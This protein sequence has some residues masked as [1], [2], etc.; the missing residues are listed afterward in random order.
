MTLPITS[1]L[2]AALAILLVTLG[3]RTARQRRRSRVAIGHGEDGPLERHARAHANLA[4]YGPIFL[5]LLGLAE[6]QGVPPVWLSVLALAFFVGRLMHAYSL[7][8]AEPAMAEVRSMR[9]YG[10][11]MAGMSAT[12]LGLL[13]LAVTLLLAAFIF[14]G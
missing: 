5:V 10:W 9:R 13:A 11:R 3:L 1:M 7:I 4:E 6:L 2:A 14:T 12:F 8:I